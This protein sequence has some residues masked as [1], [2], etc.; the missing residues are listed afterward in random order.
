M[1]VAEN[2]T[3]KNE[4]TC[5]SNDYAFGNDHMMLVLWKNVS[6]VI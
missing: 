5:H 3:Y 4:Y 1:L 6:F 2:V